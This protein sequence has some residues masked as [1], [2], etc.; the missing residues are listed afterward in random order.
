MLVLS[1]LSGHEANE[2]AQPAVGPAAD[3]PSEAREFT[4]LWKDGSRPRVF[5]SDP[6]QLPMASGINAR[7][8]AAGHVAFA[9]LPV[10]R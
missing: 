4:A 2:I 5:R 3:P 1:S 7:P 8:D 10:L 6:T 9:Q